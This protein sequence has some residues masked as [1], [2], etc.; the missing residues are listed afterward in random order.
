MIDISPLELICHNEVYVRVESQKRFSA[1]II[2]I[3]KNPDAWKN[4]IPQIPEKHRNIIPIQGNYKP[5][6]VPL[7]VSGAAF[8]LRENLVL[9][10]QTF[11][12]AHTFY[13]E[14]IV[15]VIVE[16][17]NRYIPI[18]LASNMSNDRI[19]SEGKYISL[20]YSCLVTS[21]SKDFEIVFL[22]RPSEE[23]SANEYQAV[24]DLYLE[25]NL[26]AASVRKKRWFF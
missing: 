13:A 3:M 24:V 18:R 11:N 20:N 7:F 26:P 1:T 5:R 22:E 2:C 6:E 16:G 21:E 8:F 9:L 4:L 14:P 25:K 17:S 23:I 19:S 10:A 15:K 12:C